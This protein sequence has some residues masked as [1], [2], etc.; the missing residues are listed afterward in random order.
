MKAIASLLVLS[1]L[2]LLPNA[3]AAAVITSPQE[4]AISKEHLPRKEKKQLHKL[5]K[6][7]QKKAKTRK[8]KFGRIGLLILLAG[9]VSL[10]L[11]DILFLAA[12]LAAM[13]FGII[14]LMKDEKKTAALIAVA[15]PAALILIALISVG[16]DISGD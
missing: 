7:Q 14:G 2:L 6:Q 12:L 4:V 1:F 5:D 13:V 10:L 16:I 9:L 15:V 3:E 8:S 11:T